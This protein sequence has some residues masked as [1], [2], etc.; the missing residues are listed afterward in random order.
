MGGQF[1]NDPQ[2]I[3]GTRTPRP[4]VVRLETARDCR[5]FLAK[6]VNATFR[7]EM[8]PGK[9][10]KLGYLVGIILRSIEAQDLDARLT[11]L[12]KKGEKE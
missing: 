12:E 5:K 2:G 6:I 9:A 8:L 1:L 4:R 3:T 11:A 7:D 10:G